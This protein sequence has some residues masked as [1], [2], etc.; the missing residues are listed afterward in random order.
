M[1]MDPEQA[2]VVLDAAAVCGVATQNLFGAI[3]RN[4]SGDL[5]ADELVSVV[6]EY[7]A[8]KEAFDSAIRTRGVI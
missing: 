6:E 4:V 1:T 3:E 8:A 5:P 2:V 7:C